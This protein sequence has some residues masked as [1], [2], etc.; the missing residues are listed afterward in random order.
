MK[1][2]V[3][4]D[5]VTYT[6]NGES[7]T[8]DPG[9]HK[10]YTDKVKDFTSVSGFIHHFF[11]PF[12]RDG[13]SKRVAEREQVEQEVILRRWDLSG[14][15]ACAFGTVVHNACENLLLDQEYPAPE[16]Q[17]QEDYINTAKE[18]ISR[19]KEHFDI[20]SPEIITWDDTLKL[21]GTAD[22]LVKHKVTG[23]YSILDWKTNKQIRTDNRY[24]KF[25]IGLAGDIPDNNYNHYKIQL[26]VYKYLLI[27]QGVIPADTKMSILWITKD[28]VVPYAIEDMQPQIKLMIDWWVNNIRDKVTS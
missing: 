10:Y 11:T 24:N 21:C 26:N 25:G 8:F 3:S 9:P 13:I 6:H 4:T 12:D 22:I 1:E 17:K 20:V 23:Q 28:R 18:Y 7:I 14:E 5:T 15:V 2:T 27:L 19:L 16:G